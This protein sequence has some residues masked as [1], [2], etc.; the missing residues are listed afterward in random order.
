MSC[1]TYRGHCTS[2]P[3]RCLEDEYIKMNCLMK[4]LFNQFKT[5]RVSG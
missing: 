1:W 3:A 5:N 4:K 2:D